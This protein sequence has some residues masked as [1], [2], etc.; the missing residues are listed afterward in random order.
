MNKEI[1]YETEM[2]SPVGKLTLCAND[3]GTLVGIWLNGQKYY[4]YGLNGDVKTKDNLEIF[5]R[6]KKWLSEYFAGKSPNINKLK[7]SPIG[8][9]KFRQRV[10][11]ILCEIPYGK[12][13]TYG[14]IADIIAKERGI[15]RMSAQAVGGAVGHN[16][17]SIIIPCHRVVGKNGDLTG[18][19]GGL[20]VKK[21]LLSLEKA[22]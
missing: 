19:A 20:N 21:Y 14:E 3:D 17:I 18:Y 12:T 4:E 8:S 1:F 11:Q 6:T 13:I 2:D 15:E 5:D 22:I 9:N 10:W 16:P 7:L